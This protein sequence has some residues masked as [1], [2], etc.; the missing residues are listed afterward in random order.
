MFSKSV[1]TDLPVTGKRV[2]VRVDFNV[3]L[4][5]GVVVDDARIRAALP[6]LQFLIEQGARV[7]LISHL[8]RPAGAPDP[9][10]SLAPV[11]PVL[12]GLLGRPVRFVADTVGPE[13]LALSRA[14]GD[15]EVLLLEN[16]RFYPGEK[17]ND[18]DFAR[19]LADLGELYVND[20]FGTAHRAH[21]STAG[22][23]QYLP[24]AAGLLMAREIETL[25]ALFADPKRPFVA[26]LGG[27]KVS[28]KLGVIRKLIEV[29]DTLLIGGGMAFTFE[30]ARGNGVGAS[31]LEA[32]W[33]DPCR[34]LLALADEKN[35]QLLL[36]D[37]YVVADAFA[38]DAATQV[39]AADG[40]PESWMGLDVG[41]ATTQRYQAVLASASTVFWNG[42]MG[43]FEMPAFAA[44]TRKVAEA[45]CESD[46][47]SVI[48]GG[49]SAA[50]LA[51]FGLTDKVSF[52]STGGGASMKLLEGAELPGLAALDDT[53]RI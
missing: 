4:E 32:D 37:D 43:V 18:P 30:A 21:A 47:T 17:A 38:P 10:Y 2:V 33:V 11:A 34:E 16:V 29:V 51:A 13:A 39:V 5:G 50:A 41:P 15:G 3:P 7:I 31:L 1:V 8:G 25:G 46:A 9:A 24:A 23:A 27:S 42:P 28:D 22:I 45:I 20:A 52:I 14:L 40:I 48:G 36:P 26:V 49:D 35:C 53:E 6:T 19:K 44:G 12:S